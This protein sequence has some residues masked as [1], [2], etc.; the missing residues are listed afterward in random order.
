MLHQAVELRYGVYVAT[1]TIILVMASELG[2]QNRPPFL[3]LP[4]VQY[5]PEPCVHLLALYTA[6]LLA[7]LSKENELTLP[8]LAAVMGEPQKVKGIG[9][10]VLLA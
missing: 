5:F 6:F 1:D 9:S 3:G 4:V 8:I 10:T 7:G 2:T